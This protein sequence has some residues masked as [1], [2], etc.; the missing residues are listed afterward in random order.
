VSADTLGQSVFIPITLK[1]MSSPE[2]IEMVI[3]YDS[4]LEYVGTRSMNDVSLDIP[5]E[6]MAGRAKIHIPASEIRI[7]NISAVSEFHVWQNVVMKPQVRFDSLS[8]SSSPT[9][10]SN[11]VASTV[12]PPSGCGIEIL[13]NFMRYGDMPDI[14]VQPNPSTGE[15]RAVSSKHRSGVHLELL[16]A[17]G[18]L[19]EEKE[20]V[21]LTSSGISFDLTQYPA[22][23]YFLRVKANG[24]MRTLAVMHLK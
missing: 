1:G 9:P 12:T 21:T 17:L 7:D 19:R 6:R 2:D 13:S 24:S 23:L 3:H 18:T 11:E 10:C 5:A 20:N 8:S 15:F 14:S 22:G 4:D 16:D